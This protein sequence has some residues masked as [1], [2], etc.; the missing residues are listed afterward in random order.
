MK[1]KDQIAGMAC[2]LFNQKG[3]MN[4]TLRD[5]AQ[6]MNRAYGNITYHFA[7][8]ETLILHLFQAYLAELEKLNATFQPSANL[9][10]SLL[11]APRHTFLLSQ[12][13]A[14]FFVDYVEIQ[15]HF[16]AIATQIHQQNERRKQIHL[17][18]L[19]HLQQDG[20][21]QPHFTQDDLFYLMDL[22]GIVRTHYFILHS[23]PKSELKESE[24]LIYTNQLLKPYLTAK[25]LAVYEKCMRKI[26][27]EQPNDGVG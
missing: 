8:K 20:V 25:G 2:T 19:L 26:P 18:F 24:Y 13:F 10:E 11:E 27:W 6:A 23:Q 5:V 14:F 9:L 15:R 21:L 16:P 12:Q 17:G 22:S 3:L 4:V 7:N 1:I